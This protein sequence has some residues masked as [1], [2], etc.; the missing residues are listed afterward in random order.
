MCVPQFFIHAHFLRLILHRL[1][2]TEISY[3]QQADDKLNWWVHLQHWKN[4]GPSSAMGFLCTW[5]A[6][7]AHMATTNPDQ[8]VWWYQKPNAVLWHPTWHLRAFKEDF[9]WPSFGS[10]TLASLQNVFWRLLYN[11]QV[12]LGHIYSSLYGWSSLSYSEQT[13]THQTYF[14]SNAMT[15]WYNTCVTE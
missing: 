15:E 9:L 13:T 2:K 5:E 10:R 7:T 11:E 4:D 8:A 12:R 3:I 14:W 6:K 1:Q